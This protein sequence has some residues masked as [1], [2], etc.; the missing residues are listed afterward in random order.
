MTDT[1]TKSTADAGPARRGARVSAVDRMVQIFDHLQETGRPAT[2]YEIARAI[3]A[4]VSTVYALTEELVGKRLLDRVD[5]ALWL[6]S[7]LF[8]YGLGYARTLDLLTVAT[9]EMHELCRDA[10]ETVQIC[11]RDGDDMVVLAMAEGP[12]HF[13][14]TSRVGTRVP[15]N[16]TASGRLLVGHLPDP[17]RL[18]L[19][20]RA[21]PSPTGRAETDAEALAAAARAALADRLSIQCGESDFAVA[22]IAAPILDADRACRATISI[23]VPETKVGSRG[24]D[25]VDAVRGAAARIEQRLGWRSASESTA[26]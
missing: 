7:R 13:Q 14:V 10:G 21:R 16:W 2:G 26:G 3:Q 15:L 11:G 23:V 24:P 12:G 1:L 18:A 5:G 19:F 6:G 20:R 8:H 9:H 22:C 25:L 17:E 4:P